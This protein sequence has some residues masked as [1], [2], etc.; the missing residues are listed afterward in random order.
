MVEGYSKYQQTNVDTD[1][2]RFR[3][4]EYFDISLL[5]NVVLMADLAGN[6]GSRGLAVQKR[7]MRISLPK[8]GERSGLNKNIIAGDMRFDIAKEPMI[9]SEGKEVGKK[10]RGG[11]G[12]GGK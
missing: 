7:F 10:K 11:G 9:F 3:N 12:G 1:I 5:L 2:I 4:P 8:G 6:C